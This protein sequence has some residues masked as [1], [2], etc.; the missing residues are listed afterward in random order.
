MKNLEH[1]TKQA[2]LFSLA[3]YC[4]ALATKL[5][6]LEIFPILFSISLLLS[7]IWVVLS[8]REIIF[9]GRISNTERMLMAVFIIFFN[10]IAG[11]VYFFFLREKVIG[12]K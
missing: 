12:K 1:Q 8:L 11:I 3:F 5:F 2:F 7:L 6:H 10:I 9:S 4:I